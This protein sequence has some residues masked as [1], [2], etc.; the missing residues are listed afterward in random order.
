MLWFRLISGEMINF[1]GKGGVELGL[2]SKLEHDKNHPGANTWWMSSEGTSRWV[3]EAS[4]AN[5]FPLD[6]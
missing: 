3:M 6:S 5:S 2:Q 1:T 4:R